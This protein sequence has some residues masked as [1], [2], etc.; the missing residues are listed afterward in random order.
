MLRRTCHEIRHVEL[1]QDL[2]KE[3][4]NRE[5]VYRKF[6]EISLLRFSRGGV[7]CN[8]FVWFVE[9]LSTIFDVNGIAKSTIL[10]L[11]FIVNY[12]TPRFIIHHLLLWI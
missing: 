3:N 4:G 5:F 7:S 2:A 9:R 10:L 6:V 8:G 12:T 1:S 11:K